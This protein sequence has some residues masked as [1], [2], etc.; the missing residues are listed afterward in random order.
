MG[1]WTSYLLRESEEEA[2]AR[3]ELRREYSDAGAIPDFVDRVEQVDDIET[4]RHRQGIVRQQE[5]ALDADIH[6]GVGRHRG[7]IVVAV[8]QAA[9]VDHV[10]AQFDSAPRES[11]FA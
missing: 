1:A 4:N 3:A 11:I 2:A 7:D 6:L 5:F 9:A 10:G 8:A